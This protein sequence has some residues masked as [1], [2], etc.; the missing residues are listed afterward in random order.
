MPIPSISRCFNIPS[1]HPAPWIIL[2]LCSW[3]NPSGR[4]C[5]N[6]ILMG[7]IQALMVH[8]FNRFLPD[9]S[10]GDDFDH[11][12]SELL[13]TGNGED[14]ITIALDSTMDAIAGMILNIP[15]MFDLWSGYRVTQRGCQYGHYC[16]RLPVDGFLPFSLCPS[17]PQSHRPRH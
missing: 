3:R 7:K 16:Q 9:V 10:M 5:K 14:F 12:V 2:T 1:S 13:G 11:I 15:N 4:L 6:G 17:R 8:E